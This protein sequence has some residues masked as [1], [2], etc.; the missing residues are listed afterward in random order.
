MSGPPP[1]PEELAA[2]A[3]AAKQFNIEAFTLLGVG[4]FIIILRTCARILTVGIKRLQVDDFLVWLAAV[5]TSQRD[6]PECCR[7]S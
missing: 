5:S 1:S 2:K 3:A 4:L 6:E 7:G